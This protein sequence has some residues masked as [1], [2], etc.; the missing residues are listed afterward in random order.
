MISGSSLINWAR[1]NM[2]GKN[3]GVGLG[4]S[5]VSKKRG[6]AQRGKNKIWRSISICFVALFKVLFSLDNVTIE[7]F[8][9]Q[10]TDC[11]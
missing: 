5:T 8:K 9:V 2:N 3:R 10:I 11:I 7:N 1:Q 4:R 6:K